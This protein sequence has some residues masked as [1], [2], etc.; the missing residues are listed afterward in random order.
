MKSAPLRAWLNPSN[1]LSLG[2]R[3]K[4]R[5]SRPSLE[6]LE[7]RQLLTLIP[8]MGSD[9]TTAPAVLVDA[10]SNGQNVSASSRQSVAEA[11]NGNYAVTWSDDFGYV[12]A[13][14]YRRDGTPI[15]PKIV[16]GRTQTFDAPIQNQGHA[17]NS[18]RVAMN[19]QGDFVV[20]WD[21][22]D[23]AGTY[24]VKAQMFNA[25]GSLQGGQETIAQS[26][27]VVYEP[28]VA[29]DGSD[30]FVVAYTDWNGT[31]S[32][33]LASLTLSNGTES[34]LSPDDS[35]LPNT[36]VSVT[37]GF[38]T[39]STFGTSSSSPSVI[40]TL[41]ASLPKLNIS[42][43][44][45]ASGS[46][47]SVNQGVSKTV[48]GLVGSLTPPYN[49]EPSVSMNDSGAFV[50]AYTRDFSSGTQ[51]IVARRYDSTG[52][53]QGALFSV[54]SSGG[55]DLQPST[56][57]SDSGA[58]I[59][60]YTEAN[61]D[62]WTY[63]QEQ[64]AMNDQ[65]DPGVSTSAN[66]NP[67]TLLTYH[68]G[69]DVLAARFD[70]TGQ[71]LGTVPVAITSFDEYDPS[72]SIDTAGR[73]TIAYTSGGAFLSTQSDTGIE[74]AKL[75]T[76]DDQ[77]N[78]APGE[79]PVS[80][81]PI[82]ANAEGNFTPSVAINDSGDVIAVYT[83]WGPT[84][85][86]ITSNTVYAQAFQT[87][88]YRIEVQWPSGISTDTG[89]QLTNGQAI[90]VPVTIYRDP[91]YTGDVMISASS[92]PQ[93]IG[94]WV[95][96]SDPTD[97][98]IEQRTLH[99]VASTRLTTDDVRQSL[100]VSFLPGSTSNDV[101]IPIKISVTAAE[102]DRVTTAPAPD[103]TLLR[104]NWGVL[105]GKGFVP[106]SKVF[107]GT[108]NTPAETAA[109]SPDGTSFQALLPPDASD[110]QVVIVTPA[111]A[112]ISSNL[113][114]TI[115]DGWISSL[116]TNEGYAPH[117]LQQGSELVIHGANF[118]MDD[119]IQFGGV[120]P[121][122]G[123]QIG[124]V[125]NLTAKPFLVS[126]DGTELHVYVPRDALTGV[127]TDFKSTGAEFSST[128]TYK[129]DSYRD[130]YGFNFDNFTFNA[131][132][133]NVED[134][135][136]PDLFQM[137][138]ALGFLAAESG[139]GDNGACF[140]IA[141][142]SLKFQEHSGWIDSSHGLPG[143][144]V[145]IVN[146]LS[147]TGDLKNYIEAE[148]LAQFSQE[149]LNA[150]ADWRGE[151][152]YDAASVYA[153]LEPMLAAGDHP[154][155]CMHNTDGTGHC[156]VAYDMSGD[157]VNGFTIYVY[158]PN[159]PYSQGE[160]N[161]P[162]LHVQNQDQSEIYVSPFDNSFSF[163][164]DPDL[165]YA[166]SL[167]NLT[168]ISASSIPDTPSLPDTLSGIWDDVF[169][170]GTAEN[171]LDQIAA[172]I[173]DPTTIQ[174]ANAPIVVIPNTNGTTLSPSIAV[175]YAPRDVASQADDVDSLLTTSWKQHDRSLLGKHVA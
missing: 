44:V 120:V 136:Q 112:V 169:N 59:V 110:G 105:S 155:I 117:N 24:A 64:A 25:D 50:V 7:G 47:I 65:P 69:S 135:F 21:E 58:F 137:P 46:F 11:N 87:N 103:G 83:H 5:R 153:G 76:F 17:Y 53:A 23:G 81:T 6:N 134:L 33:V 150:K 114:Y 92:L 38:N 143:G 173:A 96:S 57:L 146:N 144:A 147:F 1:R 172:A 118:S 159:R 125:Q 170:A 14:L 142:A 107:F 165:T 174:S 166:N 55:R 72:A 126:P 94:V 28:S 67:N 90:A 95:S 160:S 73:F 89:I 130:T 49:H 162:T 54:A 45:I 99:F 13:E 133:G 163:E 41:P 127:I 85:G 124:L 131:S 164:L 82:L 88:P 111:G 84:P 32:Q 34:L 68:G 167:N 60:A 157:P 8:M 31:T 175:V 101:T 132:L 12:M 63:N 121:S 26:R 161:N 27:D 40:T 61:N 79:I 42:P 138:S 75:R 100:I 30:D 104:G 98:M 108:S 168:A 10:E 145:P 35:P 113:S 15:T 52:T 2:F 43:K 71:A 154:L 3:E 129:V 29:I 36:G 119:T 37:P 128:E 78:P 140:G 158:D 149:A 22:T 139:M 141:L 151:H 70:S 9:G 152:R 4:R 39:G 109:F 115:S 97:P 66:G 156:V 48:T 93:G 51:D 56:A 20:A 18:A 116:D 91:G 123:T 77:G 102:L 62:L 171:N 74:T 122:N 86:G 19:H 148:H 106:G 16:V 80:L